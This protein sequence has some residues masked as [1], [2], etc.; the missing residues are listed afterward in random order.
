MTVD[1]YLA[2]VEQYVDDYDRPT[3]IR[4]FQRFCKEKASC[5]DMTADAHVQRQ[6][7][8]KDAVRVRFILSFYG[9]PSP[10][11]VE[12][13]VKWFRQNHIPVQETLCGPCVTE[14]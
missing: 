11:E 4:S 8:S 3:V 13:A 12:K 14:E 1:E 5:T 2:L 7:P 6:L 10:Y 9:E